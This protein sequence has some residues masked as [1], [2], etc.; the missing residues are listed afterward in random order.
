MVKSDWLRNVPGGTLE[1]GIGFLN[2]LSWFIECGK[3]GEQWRAYAGEGLLVEVN[4]K[5]ELEAF[6]IGMTIGLAV[7]P[8]R[9]L[10]DIRKL[11]AE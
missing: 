11:V 9:I 5:D 4:T 2:S 7:L 8:D 10:E 3:Y 1:G 6:I